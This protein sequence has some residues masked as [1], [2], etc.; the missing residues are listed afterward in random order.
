MKP[1]LEQVF[2]RPVDTK[3]LTEAQTNALV[4]S[5]VKAYRKK[6]R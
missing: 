4:I 5:E 1:I 2:A 6:R 3:A